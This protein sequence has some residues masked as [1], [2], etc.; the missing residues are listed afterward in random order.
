MNAEPLLISPATLGELGAGDADKGRA[1][2]R[3]MIADARDRKPIVGPTPRPESVRLATAADEP[4]IEA[5][6][7]LDA[8]ENAVTVAPFSLPDVQDMIRAVTRDVGKGVIGLVDD[9]RGVPVAVV[10]ILADKWWWSS[11]DGGCFLVERVTFVHPEHRRSE[12]ARDLVL[13][14]RWAADRMT[15]QMGRRVYLFHGITATSRTDSKVRLLNRL[16]NYV[17]SFFIYPWPANAEGA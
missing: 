2:L 10:V 4:A 17:G 1:R 6:L 7:E 12:H 8:R 11:W 14:A 9:A 16:S 15:E 3:L 13:F 5:L